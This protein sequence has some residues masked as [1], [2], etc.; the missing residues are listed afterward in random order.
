MVPAFDQ[1]AFDLEEGE[2]SDVSR[3]D[4]GYHVIRADAVRPSST[5]PLEEV[6]ESIRQRLV[7]EG[8][9]ALAETHM[10]AISAALESGD[11]LEEA[12][13]GRDLSVATSEPL[14]A[15]DTP[16][17]LESPLLASRAFELAVGEAA[18]EPFAVPLG[19]AFIS[20]AEIQE[21]R[22]PEFDEVADEVRAELLEE[23]R[24]VRARARAEEL[25]ERAQR[26]G[27]ATAP[28]ALGLVRTELPSPVGRG[29]RLGELGT[30]SVLEQLAYSLEPGALSE[31]VEVEGGWAVL[32]VL[33]REPFDPVAFAD[34][35][36]SLERSLRQQK[37]SQFFQA[38]MNGVRDRVD[39]Q[40]DLEVYRRIVG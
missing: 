4:F 15:G 22:V 11:S 31:P 7:A 33:E 1:V 26:Q 30:G 24:L 8:A 39:V 2:I 20:L 36:A 14:A 35:R 9:G 38:Y 27:L 40:R 13:S 3:T 37:R 28:A 19:A 21:P 32:E 12:A 18:T 6:R 10:G 16:E 17:P 29:D 34:E 5:R 25:R 23:R